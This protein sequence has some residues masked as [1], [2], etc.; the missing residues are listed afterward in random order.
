MHLLKRNNIATDFYTHTRSVYVLITE[1]S[2]MKEMDKVLIK[3]STG[4]Q[5]FNVEVE[6]T[7]LKKY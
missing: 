5:K 4:G 7:F 1:I 6:K 2:S 3:H